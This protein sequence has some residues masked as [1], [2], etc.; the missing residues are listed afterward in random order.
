MVMPADDPRHG[1]YAGFQLHKERHE[2]ICGSCK[3]AGYLYTKRMKF[4]L[5]RT[6]SNIVDL[7][8]SAYAIVSAYP[9]RLL[10]ELTGIPDPKLYTY[11]GAGP[12]ARVHINTRNA[13]LGVNRA[14]LWTP[15]GIRRRVRALTAMGYS[16]AVIAEVAGLSRTAVLTVRKDDEA[17]FVRRPTATAIRA[18]Y[19]ALHMKLPPNT[20]PRDRAVVTRSKALA[21]RN[22][23]APPLAWGEIDNPTEQPVTGHDPAQY[24]SDDLLAEWDHLRGLGVPMHHAARQLGVT[25]SAIEKAVE[26]VGRRVVA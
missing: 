7:G 12:G 21:A 22:G 3:H 15:V 18:A 13:I 20:T 24:D 19:D 25:P 14:E 5:A 9:V 23:W 6:G 2:P 8:E 17:T 26:R 1:T 4:R 10:S 16:A 11:R